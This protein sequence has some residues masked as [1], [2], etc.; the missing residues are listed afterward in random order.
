MEGEVSP[1]EGRVVGRVGGT[2]TEEL[3]HGVSGE[4]PFKTE[5]KQTNKGGS[6]GI[7]ADGLEASSDNT[8]AVY[9]WIP[10][11]L[12]HSDNMS[13]SGAKLFIIVVRQ[14]DDDPAGRNIALA[15]LVALL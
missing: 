3:H 6:S 8:F 1:D 10:G 12:D 5:L 9:C 7:S 11:S 15:R 13:S 4:A 14:Q 2:I